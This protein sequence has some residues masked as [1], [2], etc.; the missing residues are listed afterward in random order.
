M[1]FRFAALIA[2]VSGGCQL[3]SG[4]TGFEFGETGAGAMPGGGGGVGA[5][6]GAAS[7]GGAAGVGGTGAGGTAGGGGV[8]PEC[9]DPEGAIAWRKL[10]GADGDQSGFGIT[11]AGALL[12]IAGLYNDGFNLDGQEIATP[13]NPSGF[14][15]WL[16]PATGDSTVAKGFGQVTSVTGV[17]GDSTGAVYVFGRAAANEAYVTRLTTTGSDEWSTPFSAGSVEIEDA[18]FVDGR[19]WVAGS[20]NDSS[21]GLTV[22]VTSALGPGEPSVDGFVLALNATSGVLVEDSA[23]AFFEVLG[24]PN[25][26][27]AKALAALTDVNVVVAGEYNGA[28][29]LPSVGSAT[30]GTRDLF[31]ANLLGVPSDTVSATAVNTV[32]QLTVRDATID[33]LDRLWVVGRLGDVMNEATIDV[34]TL[35]PAASDST[36]FGASDAA[37]FTGVAFDG[38]GHGVLVGNVRGET[39]DADAA[40]NGDTSTVDGLVVSVDSNLSYLWGRRLHSAVGTTRFHDAV[41]STGGVVAAVGEAQGTI[42][43]SDGSSLQAEGS[44]YEV[45][46]L[47]F[48]PY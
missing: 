16:D 34:L 20:F 41:K 47:G 35:A 27:S 23:R 15:A 21:T 43:L 6:G 11:T 18:V 25:H 2:V 42:M 26:E 10:F 44:G 12:A 45:I 14:V 24:G 31:V 4:G 38:C 37:E 36:M 33:P 7:V 39:F 30:A 5:S 22:G 28:I 1:R 17:T 9:A 19:V 46:V 3:L 29:N 40:L 8:A 32:L 13:T 48:A